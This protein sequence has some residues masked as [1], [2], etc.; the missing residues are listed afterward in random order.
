MSRRRPHA[1]WTQPVQVAAPVVQGQA[2]GSSAH[3]VALRRERIGEHSASTAWQLADLVA[4][5]HEQR[6]ALGVPKGAPISSV[7]DQQ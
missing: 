3:L 4:A 6:A 5:I 2:V 7:A 1:D